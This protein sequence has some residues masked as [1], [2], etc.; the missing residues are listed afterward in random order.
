MNDPH[1]TVDATWV[2]HERNVVWCPVHQEEAE[3][4]GCGRDTTPGATI[5]LAMMIAILIMGLTAA[6]ILLL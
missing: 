3:S 5:V 4:C 1:D 2:P 6:V